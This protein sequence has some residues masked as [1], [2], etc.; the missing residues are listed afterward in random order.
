MV[1]CCMNCFIAV[2]NA[3]QIRK[4]SVQIDALSIRTSSGPALPSIL[5]TPQKIITAHYIS[6]TSTTG[7]NQ[8]QTEQTAAHRNSNSS[9]YRHLHVYQ[10][11]QLTTFNTYLIRNLPAIWIH[12]R[13]DMYS[14]VV[15]KP[16]YILISTIVLFT[17][18]HGQS[19]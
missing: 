9:F 10:F 12:R 6:S 13:H 2:Y 18:V 15:N 19:Q 14:C 17:Q 3:V 4:V 16:L 1:V 11:L 8:S 5:A 7:H